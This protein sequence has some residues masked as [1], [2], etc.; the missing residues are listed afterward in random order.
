MKVLTLSFRNAPHSDIPP[1]VGS[2]D[3]WHALMLLMYIYP[4]L[5]GSQYGLVTVQGKIWGS[6][7]VSGYVLLRHSSSC[8]ALE[9]GVCVR[10]VDC[11]GWMPRAAAVVTGGVW[12][13]VCMYCMQAI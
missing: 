3:F 10:V 5:W 6:L 13:G 9:G 11:T 7:Y 2:C 1:Y 12:W 8:P 4:P